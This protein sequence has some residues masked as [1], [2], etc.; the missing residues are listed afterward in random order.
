MHINTSDLLRK[1]L[2]FEF[3]SLEE[4]IHLHHHAQ[5]EE[6][7]YVANEMRKVH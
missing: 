6:L 5:T 7:M 2:N 4:A 1:A 3:L